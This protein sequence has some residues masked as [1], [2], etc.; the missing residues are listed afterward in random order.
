MVLVSVTIVLCIMQMYMINKS[1]EFYDQVEVIPIYLTLLIFMNC[2]CG[3]LILDEYLMYTTQELFVLLGCLVICVLGI[4]MLVK[5]PKLNLFGCLKRSNSSEIGSEDLDS[6]NFLRVND[7]YQPIIEKL[8]TEFV[9]N[10][11]K[12]NSISSSSST[13]D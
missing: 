5:K 1:I 11:K 12:L 7:N 13:S 10:H 6:E 8:Q 3:G 2:F 9:V 4:Y